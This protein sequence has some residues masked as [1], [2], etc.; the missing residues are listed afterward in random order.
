ML[1]GA[2]TSIPVALFSHSVLMARLGFLA[3]GVVWLGLIA[4]GI[5]KAR[6]RQF[7]NH[8]RLML[9]MAAACSRPAPTIALER[10]SAFMQVGT[11]GSAS[12]ARASSSCA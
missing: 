9:M 5:M 6:R 11:D 8:A 4:L 12:T 3:Q 2:V 1:L 7:S 10:F